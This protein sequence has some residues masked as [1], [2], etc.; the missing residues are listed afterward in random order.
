VQAIERASTATDDATWLGNGGRGPLVG[1]GR[2]LRIIRTGIRL[3]HGRVLPVDTTTQRRDAAPTAQGDA[4]VRAKGATRHRDASRRPEGPPQHAHGLCLGGPQPRGTGF[5]RWLKGRARGRRRSSGEDTTGQGTGARMGL[6]PTTAATQTLRRPRGQ[7]ASADRGPST[8]DAGT[9]A[10]A[11][12]N[13]QTTTP[14]AAMQRPCPPVLPRMPA[15]PRPTASH[16]D[17]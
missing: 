3:H 2:G 10:A 5:R 4:R 9:A 17:R 12:H 6:A 14:H 11:T 16:T 1:V 13:G 8:T 7:R 15:S